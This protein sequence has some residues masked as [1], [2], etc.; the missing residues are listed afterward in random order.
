MAYICNNCGHTF[1]EPK[2]YIERH[3]F[4]YGPGETIYTCP[5]C[6]VDD[7]SESDE[8]GYSYEDYLADKADEAYDERMCEED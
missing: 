1:S 2:V 5:Y 4:S 6:G 7:M 8:P 3:G